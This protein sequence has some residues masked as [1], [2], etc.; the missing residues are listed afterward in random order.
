LA[1][2]I[3]ITCGPSITLSSSIVCYPQLSVGAGV[4]L[5]GNVQS[6]CLDEQRKLRYERCL[7]SPPTF[8]PQH[9]KLSP[10][11]PE[12]KVRRGVLQAHTQRRVFVWAFAV[13]ST[14]NASIVCTQGMQMHCNTCSRPWAQT[15]TLLLHARRAR[16]R[17]GR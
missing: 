9:S 5:H 6:R 3:W 7:E 4:Q 1:A 10:K 8:P 15:A 17:W 14:P 13:I 12:I 11:E 2:C 16:K